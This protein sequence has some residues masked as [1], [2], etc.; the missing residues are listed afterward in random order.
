MAISSLWFAAFAGRILHRNN[1]RNAVVRALKASLSGNNGRNA[2]V[3]ALKAGLSRNNGRNAFVGAL[4]AGLSGNNGRNA[5]VGADL[6]RML[7]TASNKVLSNF[8]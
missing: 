2:F 1:G 3:G 4:K 7:Y 5:F 8:L 6:C